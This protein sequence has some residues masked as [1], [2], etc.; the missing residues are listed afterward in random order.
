MRE[1]TGPPREQD[2][3][4]NRHLVYT[5]GYGFVAAPGNEVDSRGPARLRRQG[6]AGHRPPGAADRAEGVADLLRR[7]PESARVRRRR[8]VTRTQELDY[9]ESGGTGQKNTTYDGKG[10]VPVGS[11]LNRLLYA[12][13][14]GEENLLL[15]SD[16]NDNSKILYERNP[17][18]ASQ[19]VA[20][21]LTLDDNPYPAIVDGRVVW[22]VDAYTTS[23]AYPYSDSAEPGGD[24]AGHRPPTRAWSC[25]SRATRSTTSAT[26]SRPRSTPTTAPST[27][28]A[29]DDE[30]P[31]L[32]DLA[33]GLPRHHQAADA[34]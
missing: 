20:P 13:K 19:K 8:A 27:L 21:F 3:W 15:S 16:I 1:L 9:P 32:Q 22:I 11:F 25:S 14:Y 6:H 30:D 18:T 33:Q 12:A 5:H 29:W 2:N 10:G 34:R 28:Y 31:I 4:I 7:V 17:R 26:R 23:N 24:D